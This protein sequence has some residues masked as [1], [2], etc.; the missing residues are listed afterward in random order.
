[1]R[2]NNLT[3]EPITAE[4]LHDL[5][6]WLKTGAEKILQ[7]IN[8]H[9]TWVPE[10]LY[11]SLRYPNASRIVAWMVTRNQKALGWACGG[12]ESDRYGKLEFFLWDAWTI[13]LRE[14]A[15]ED[16]VEG[17]RD[18][19]IDYMK[20]WAKANGCWRLATMSA[21]KLEALGWTKGHT[22]YYLPL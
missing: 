21:R 11:A 5:W 16:D 4:K 9:S 22:I 2:I 8:P 18:Q 14:R 1:V 12:I 17:A 10:D 6:P 20:L 7:R 15:P 3:I 19:L 13:P